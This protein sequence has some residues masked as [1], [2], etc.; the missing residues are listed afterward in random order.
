MNNHTT[1]HSKKVE[2]CCSRCLWYYWK[3]CVYPE[4]HVIDDDEHN[5][6]NNYLQHILHPNECKYF[7]PKE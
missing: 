5:R 3:R 6:M 7:K 4:Q 1:D 2:Q